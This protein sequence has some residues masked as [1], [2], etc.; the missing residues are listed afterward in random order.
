M[1]ALVSPDMALEALLVAMHRALVLRD[2]DLVAIVTWIS[3]VGVAG[4]PAERQ[5]HQRQGEDSR[6]PWH[7]NALSAG[8]LYA[9][10]HV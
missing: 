5:E 1:S 7:G 10:E 8:C 4:K 6:G 9:R 3:F 2:V